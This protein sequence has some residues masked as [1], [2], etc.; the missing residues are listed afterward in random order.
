MAKKTQLPRKHVGKAMTSEQEKIV[1]QIQKDKKYKT[2]LEAKHEYFENQEEY[3]LKKWEKD[4]APSLAQKI[5]ND[6]KDEQKKRR[7]L[8]IAEAKLGVTMVLSQED[9]KTIG[10]K[11]DTL[12]KDAVDIVRKKL[13]LPS[14]A[15]LK[16]KKKEGA[17]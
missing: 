6:V 17:Q 14:R 5:A 8:T 15:E 13:G 1:E 11:E 2:M 3:D 4:R 12:T 10:I 16:A 7:I 9:C